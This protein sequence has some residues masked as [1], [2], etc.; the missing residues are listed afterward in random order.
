MTPDYQFEYEIG[1]TVVTKFTGDTAVVAGRIQMMGC[2]DEYIIEIV[3]AKCE[4]LQV[5]AHQIREDNRS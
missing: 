3:G 5:Q 4:P 1:Q 2:V